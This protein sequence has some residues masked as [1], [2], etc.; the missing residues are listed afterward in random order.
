MK[1]SQKRWK[2]D[3][4]NSVIATLMG[5][6][7]LRPRQPFH[8]KRRGLSESYVRNAASIALR[9]GSL[10][11][12]RCRTDN[13]GVQSSSS[14]IGNAFVESRICSLQRGVRS[15]ETAGVP[16]S[17]SLSRTSY[18]RRKSNYKQKLEHDLL[19]L[20][21]IDNGSMRKSLNSHAEMIDGTRLFS[22]SISNFIPNSEKSVHD[23]KDEELDAHFNPDYREQQGCIACSR[24]MDRISQQERCRSKFE[25][26]LRY[27]SY[28]HESSLANQSKKQNLKRYKMAKEVQGLGVSGRNQTLN[29]ILSLVSRI[30][31]R[32]NLDMKPGLCDP[33]SL[34]FRSSNS[35]SIDV[36]DDE[37]P[38][39]LPV[40]ELEAV[41]G[42]VSTL[43]G[44]NSTQN[45]PFATENKS[46]EQTP[47]KNDNLGSKSGKGSEQFQISLGMEETMS[48]GS[49]VS[50]VSS[51]SFSCFD[52]ALNNPEA[53]IL[54][55][56]DE[57]DS[58]FENHCGKDDELRGTVEV[59]SR[60]SGDCESESKEEDGKS[61][62]V[63]EVFIPEVLSLSLHYTLLV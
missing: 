22:A 12:G 16:V 17:S 55:N 27:G 36:G 29:E 32:N 20:G 23:L 28:S 19:H 50:E 57:M 56:R 11:S 49:R 51:C 40:S 39:R 13:V 45:E 34:W 9:P 26:V 33:T 46:K 54:G 2:P 47:F 58:S 3:R 59:F 41:K 60:T 44:W 37:S 7:R 31:K 52:S 14:K 15:S 61:S 10:V 42:T 1:D 24:A 62:A 6:D 63:E 38:K 43:T 5:F 48:P 21:E 25:A 30:S 53:Y 4:K 18:D 35:R 8:E